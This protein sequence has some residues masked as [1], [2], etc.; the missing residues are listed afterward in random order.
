MGSP[1]SSFVLEIYLQHHESNNI[2]NILNKQQVL[3]YFR[4][5]HDLIVNDQIIPNI[6]SVLTDLNSLN[7][8]LSFSLE[9]E[10][11]KKINFLDVT[12]TKLIDSLQFS[13]CRELT[14]TDIIIPANSCHQPEQKYSSMRY[15]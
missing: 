3:E 1:S 11:N 8:K 10:Q 4:C 9:L 7:P 12:V 14:T 2:L 5:A 15:L 13:V 6:N